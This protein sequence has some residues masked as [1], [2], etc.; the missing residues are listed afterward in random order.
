MS[1]TGR[2]SIGLVRALAA[3]FPFHVLMLAADELMHRRFDAAKLSPEHVAEHNAALIL[4]LAAAG[5]PIETLERA[6]EAWRL[7]NDQRQI[8]DGL[9][10]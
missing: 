8:L 3:Q 7:V 9:P 1:M 2:E 4:K 6:I 5:I 10:E